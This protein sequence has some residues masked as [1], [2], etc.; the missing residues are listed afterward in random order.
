MNP[1]PDFVLILLKLVASLLYPVGLVCILLAI[2][3]LFL[4]KEKQKTGKYVC[5]TGA[6]GLFLFSQPLV[7]HYLVRSLESRYLPQAVYPQSSAIVLLGGAVTPPVAPR[8]YPETSD[9]AD[10]V[11]HAVRLYKKKFA[12]YIITSGRPII[13][14]DKQR[15]NEARTTHQLLTELFAVN[16]DDIILEEHSRTTH[17]H[18][19]TM[20][21]MFAAR[22]MKKEI[23]LVTSALHM[24][25][26]VGV[27]KKQG[28]AVHPAPTDYIMEKRALSGY[29]DFFPSAEALAL[30]TRAIHEFY[31]IIGYKLFG[32]I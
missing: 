11:L 19:I 30:S 10:R 3:L 9:A 28:F 15:M 32:W 20:D 18:A 21:R 29:L 22:G 13:H 31:G 14:F 12:P 26:S 27:F 6:I 7:A 16:S 17:D 5:L 1:M 2:G 23:I 8:I 25:R 4:F 24:T